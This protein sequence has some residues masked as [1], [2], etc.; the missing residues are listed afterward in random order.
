[1]MPMSMPMP[2]LAPMRLWMSK[3]GAAMVTAAVRW[4]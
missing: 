2:T 3:S 4:G 1:L